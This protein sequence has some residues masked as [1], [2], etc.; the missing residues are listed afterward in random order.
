MTRAEPLDIPADFAELDAVDHDVDLSQHA[1]WLV[2]VLLGLYAQRLPLLYEVVGSVAA[3]QGGG[4]YLSSDDRKQ[5]DRIDRRVRRWHKK[6]FDRV[7]VRARKEALALADFEGEYQ[8]RV[9]RRFTGRSIKKVGLRDR[10]ASVVRLTFEGRTLDE[11]LATLQRA[12]VNAVMRDIT[13]G[14][15]AE[16]GAETILERVRGDEDQDQAGTTAKTRRDIK[17]V[18]LTANTHVSNA[19]RV[20][21]AERNKDLF[22]RIIHTSVLDGRTSKICI[23]LAGKVYRV[24]EPIRVPP[25]HWNC[26]SMLRVVQKGKPLPN[27]PTAEQWLKAMPVARQNEILGEEVAGWWRGGQIELRGLVTDNLR[28]LSLSELRRKARRNR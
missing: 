25:L 5:L 10:K 17:R 1:A 6:T 21:I 23:S 2:L 15:K 22:D 3:I 4:L 19:M 20:R 16:E 27:V 11:H 28:P 18:A 9:L 14:V 26:R 7:R 12:S 8:A 13:E 24:G